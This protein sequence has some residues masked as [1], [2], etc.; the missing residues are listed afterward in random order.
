MMLLCKKYVFWPPYPPYC[1][2]TLLTMAISS[3]SSPYP[4]FSS[5]PACPQ[6]CSPSSLSHHPPPSPCNWSLSPSN[7]YARCIF[8]ALV[9]CQC[10]SCSC[11]ISPSRLGEEPIH[12]LLPE[13]IWDEFTY[14]L[15]VFW[16]T[17][18]PA[19][20]SCALAL[21]PSHKMAALQCVHLHLFLSPFWPFW[22]PHCPF[23]KKDVSFF[24]AS[25]QSWVITC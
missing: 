5:Q 18:S 9:H 1:L 24:S 3:S 15:E 22:P 7:S 4:A 16:E 19:A 17:T 14:H 2:T 13:V 12:C 6:Q 10:Q 21:N 23:T 20:T 8:R 11:S 25:F